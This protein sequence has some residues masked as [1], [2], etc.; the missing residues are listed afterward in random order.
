MNTFT[1]E[2]FQTFLGTL[3]YKPND[4]QQK[5]L[6]SVAFGS[7][8]I[9]VSAVAGSGKTS[10]I[11]MIVALI[12][13]MESVQAT[14]NRSRIL[15][16][17][18]NVSIRDELTE[19]LKDYDV[20]AV[21]MNRLGNTAIT[22]WLKDKSK[23][24]K[25]EE[26]KYPDT[27]KSVLSDKL[28]RMYTTTEAD[29]SG[30]EVE[31]S[32]WSLSYTC[33][34]LAEK[35]LLAFIEPDNTDAIWWMSEHHNTDWKQAKS[36]TIRTCVEEVIPQI[37]RDGERAWERY[38]E[39]SFAEQIVLPIKENMPIEQ[40]DW[41][42]GDEAQDW[43][44][45]QQALATRSLKPGGRAIIVGDV[46]Q[47]I[48][49][50]GGADDKSWWRMQQV[51]DAELFDLN[52]TY[53]CP[54]KVTDIARAAVP[55]I[56][57]R[58]DA[59]AGE[60]L[61][62]IE[63]PIQSVT[64]TSSKLPGGDTPAPVNIDFDDLPASHLY[65]YLRPDTLIMGRMNATVAAAF[66][67]IVKIK[68]KR[69]SDDNLLV[70]VIGRDISASVLGMTKVLGKM[71]G[72]TWDMFDLFVDKYHKMEVSRVKQY[73]SPSMQEEKLAEVEDN[74]DTLRMCYNEFEATSL[75]AFE[76]KV[77]QVFGI[78]QNDDQERIAKRKDAV[79]ICTAHK[80]KGL[81]AHTAVILNPDEF[82]KPREGE[83]SWQTQ[84]EKN[85]LYVAVTRA[86][87]R[88]IIVKNPETDVDV[89]KLS[90]TAYDTE[91]AAKAVAESKASAIAAMGND[92]IPGVNVDAILGLTNSKQVTA[93]SN[94]DTLNALLAASEQ[95]VMEPSL[96]SRIKIA[97]GRNDKGAADRGLVIA[98]D[99]IDAGLWDGKGEIWFEY[100]YTMHPDLSLGKIALTD[101]I[102][103][104]VNGEKHVCLPDD[105]PE[106]L[107][108]PLPQPTSPALEKLKLA[109][110]TGGLSSPQGD[111]AI[112]LQ[113]ALLA[114]D[115]AALTQM[116]SVLDIVIS[117]KQTETEAV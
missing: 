14:K 72:F 90:A 32:T 70:Q 102:I 8:N 48:M 46:S 74:F 108:R 60:I 41:I 13:Y 89:I 84:Q 107:M 30:K 16:I 86:M 65:N 20:E 79:S 37:L 66:F 78:S 101:L 82:M 57:S 18:F 111:K 15:P 73:R 71:K 100:V 3:K 96:Q 115:I 106:S 109:K 69:K 116:R 36:D 6:E 25:F 31:R 17:A 80:S 88:L 99:L 67:E 39:I 19:R 56:Q 59:P 24:V 64:P 1:Q 42:L 85:L 114:M 75:P 28:G 54:S 7:G 113:Q 44:V 5:V 97:K 4:F 12:R 92:S 47:A 104:D 105:N 98:Q 34:G 52:I 51:F 49:G 117:L 91:K 43:N 10:M 29:G 58:P 40:Y 83:R 62:G 21:N 11:V 112:A 81:E 55:Q 93:D 76:S 2:H 23:R 22:N 61:Q 45:G 68:A 27:A 110:A 63:L 26:K 9:Q 53:R 95:P 87:E 35:C 33:A 38:N 50:F 94:D 77:K 103:K